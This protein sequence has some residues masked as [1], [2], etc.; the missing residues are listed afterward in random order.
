M[1]QSPSIYSIQLLNDLHHY[2]PELLYQPEH[3]QNVQDVLQY[4]RRVANQNPYTNGYNSYLRNLSSS[5]SSASSAPSSSSS[6]SSA[7]S[8]PSS[9]SSADLPFISS[10]LMTSSN[11]TSSVRNQNSSMSSSSRIRFT[12]PLQSSNVP[13]SDAQSG[14]DQL[15]T[16]FLA[17]MLNM[18][19]NSGSRA[20]YS[21][22]NFLQ[23]VI[24]RPTEDEINNAT[25]ITLLQS[26][27]QDNC[28][29]CQDPMEVSQEIR[30]ID[31]CG[32]SFHKTC[33]DPWFRENVRCPTCRYDIRDFSLSSS[34]ST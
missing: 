17:G 15:L 18:G 32:H 34:A 7:S 4:I 11:S 9:S 16:Q 1:R 12:M 20:T 8:A 2:F 6:S 14:G 13:V 33:I 27:S 30:I 24:V 5:S 19:L 23:P 29:I 10:P 26:N 25:Y 3:F 28:A 22:E 31:H 21:Y